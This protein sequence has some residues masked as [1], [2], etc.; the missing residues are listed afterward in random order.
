M[1]LKYAIQIL[2]INAGHA[3]VIL[4]HTDMLVMISITWQKK[5]VMSLLDISEH[6]YCSENENEIGTKF[7]NDSVSPD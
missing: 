2:Y 3:R 5:L 7:R 1:V 4:K 6:W